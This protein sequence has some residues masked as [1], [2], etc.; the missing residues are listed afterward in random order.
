MWFI[1]SVDTM[2]LGANPYPQ[3]RDYWPY[4]DEHGEYGEYGG[5]VNSLTKTVV[6]SKL[7]DAPG[8]ALMDESL[9]Y[10]SSSWRVT[11]TPELTRT[12]LAK[13]LALSDCSSCMDQRPLRPANTGTLR[14]RTANGSVWP[15]GMAG[16]DSGCEV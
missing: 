13:E 10:W 6:S 1:D 8:G 5:E 12:G 16:A 9:T 15:W 2:V 4:A 11:P 7:D 14:L 3:S